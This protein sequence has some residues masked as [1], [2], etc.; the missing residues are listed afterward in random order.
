[1]A[2]SDYSLVVPFLDDSPTYARGVEFGMLFERLKKAKKV[3]ELITTD[4]EEQV[5]LLL[6]RTGWESVSVKQIGEGWSEIKATR[7]K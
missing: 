5:T 2:D 3:K 6:N 4:N 1:M 7:P